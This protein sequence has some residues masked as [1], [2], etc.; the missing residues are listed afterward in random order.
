[1]L[2]SR[3]T[4]SPR[5]PVPSLDR[6]NGWPRL[7]DHRGPA[8]DQSALSMDMHYRVLPSRE[9]PRNKGGQRGAMLLHS[10]SD[11]VVPRNKG[12]QRGAMLL[13]STSDSTTVGN[14]GSR[15]RI[16]HLSD[17]GNYLV[18]D[19]PTARELWPIPASTALAH[20]ENKLGQL[21][22]SPWNFLDL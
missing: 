9:E 13:H 16:W 8:W 12:G 3:N 5:P 10:T 7:G 19:I 14:I 4:R 20:R 6:T 11:G 18:F 2:A 21:R 17:H 22:S 1:M 15:L